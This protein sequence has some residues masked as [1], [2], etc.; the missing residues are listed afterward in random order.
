MCPARIQSKRKSTSS[1]RAIN[2]EKEIKPTIGDLQGLLERIDPIGVTFPDEKQRLLTAIESIKNWES[3]VPTYKDTLEKQL[4]TIAHGY[5]SIALKDRFPFPC[6]ANVTCI[7]PY[8]NLTLVSTMTGAGEL[9][10]SFGSESTTEKI[11]EGKVKEKDE[12]IEDEPFDPAIA[13]EEQ[14]WEEFTGFSDGLSGKLREY[15]DLYLSIG[16]WENFHL[17]ESIFQW[18]KSVRRLLCDPDWENNFEE[19]IVDHIKDIFCI[20]PVDQLLEGNRKFENCAQVSP[21]VL[22]ALLDAIPL[23]MKNN[24]EE[25]AQERKSSRRKAGFNWADRIAKSTSIIS[26]KRALDQDASTEEVNKDAMDV[27]KITPEKGDMNGEEGTM[28]VNE[29]D[30]EKDEAPKSKKAKNVDKGPT[31]DTKTTYGDENADSVSK[32]K[33]TKVLFLRPYKD[34]DVQLT[35]PMSTLIGYWIRCLLLLHG[36]LKEASNFMTETLKVK[37][38]KATYAEISS[39]VEMA[40]CRNLP[41]KYR[42]ILE[43]VLLDS[44]KWRQKA[45]LILKSDGATSKLSIEEAEDVLTKGEKLTIICDELEELKLHVNQYRRWIQKFEKSGIAVGLA[46]NVDLNQMLQD[47]IALL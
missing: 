39:R 19:E 7:N 44:T 6:L 42:Q 16:G 29:S 15:D 34:S 45:N 18:I 24:G 26:R 33:F 2:V 35:A 13:E 17:Y 10:P 40:Q 14:Y 12:E 22:D 27:L 46:A 28:D 1:T 37:N 47:G 4:A 25:D 41:K 3:E 32:P 23:V 31:K 5:S 38:Q 9:I 36:R 30:N 21:A 8:E 11:S 20:Y 43:S